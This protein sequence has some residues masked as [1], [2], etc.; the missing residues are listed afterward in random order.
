MANVSINNDLQTLVDRLS[1]L[2][3]ATPRND[4][5]YPAIK[6]SYTAASNLLESS[7][8]I[9]ID[10]EGGDYVEFASKMKEAM[11]AFDEAEKKIAKISKVIK[12]TAQV[13]DIVGKIA[14]KV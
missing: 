9:A 6:A 10:K 2:K 13:I 4:P 5:N 3:T 12:I 7:L 14:A 1:A 11:V 8:D